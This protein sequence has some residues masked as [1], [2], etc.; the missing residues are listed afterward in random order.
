M[1]K[2]CKS[3]RTLILST[4]V[5]LT[6]SAWATNGVIEINQARALAG[7]VTAG[8]TAGFPV[9][10][11]VPGSYRLTGN[12]TVPDANT[13]AIHISSG[14][15]SLDLNGFTIAGPNTCNWTAPLAVACLA[16]GSGTGVFSNSKADVRNGVIRG[17]GSEGV[18]TF[19]GKL[20]DL[21]VSENGGTGV[22]ALTNAAIVNRVISEQNGGAGFNL[23]GGILTE[24]AANRNGNG[25]FVLNDVRV[26]GVVAK[27][28]AGQG[29]NLGSGIIANSIS[30]FNGGDGIHINSRAVVADSLIYSNGGV[31]LNVV[32]GVIGYR[33]NTIQGNTGGQVT[34]VGALQVGPNV[35]G[36]ALCP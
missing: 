29:I 19:G 33:G 9:T 35:C 10:I 28:N 18:V 1:S 12:L 20:T 11:S 8:D 4:A 27:Q 7:G 3:I 32:G 36:V 30:S 14:N 23:D 24:S 26:T 2:K 5:L 21:L 13:T 15:V 34:G 31:G 22:R 6:A 16:N 25:G 17:F